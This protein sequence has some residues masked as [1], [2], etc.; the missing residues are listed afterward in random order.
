M[1]GNLS[2]RSQTVPAT[3]VNQ[4]SNDPSPDM[5]NNE[6][7]DESLHLRRG[8]ESFANSLPGTEDCPGREDEIEYEYRQLSS[9]EKIAVRMII[10]VQF[11]VAKR[12]F[13]EA[14]RPYDVKDVI[15]QYSAGHLD[16]L[17]RIKS[18]QLR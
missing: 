17:S 5:K 3:P 2:H 18:L 12:K 14:L 7:F 6:V 4:D 13:K 10:R 9:S 8:Q 11:L 1:A 15:E 16:M